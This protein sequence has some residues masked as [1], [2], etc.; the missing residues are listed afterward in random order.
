MKS[1]EQSRPA[2]YRRLPR[3]LRIVYACGVGNNWKQRIRISDRR[4]PEESKDDG[5]DGP[6]QLAI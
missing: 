3:G 5:G 6:R 2:L 1:N 4:K